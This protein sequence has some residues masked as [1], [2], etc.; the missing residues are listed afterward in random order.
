MH[1]GNMFG[2]K[3]FLLDERSSF[4]D[5]R[6]ASIAALLIFVVQR[7]VHEFLAERAWAKAEWPLL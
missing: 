4:G 2:V 5:F 1:Y 6:M 7:D 3:H